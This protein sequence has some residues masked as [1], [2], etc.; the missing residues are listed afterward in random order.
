MHCNL[1]NRCDLLFGSGQTRW[2]LNGC[3]NRNAFAFVCCYKLQRLRLSV[4]AVIVVDLLLY[5]CLMP[6]DTPT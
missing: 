6:F 3:V 1:E 2:I 5:M 4:A